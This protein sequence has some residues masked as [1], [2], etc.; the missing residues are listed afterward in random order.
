M[1]GLLVDERDNLLIIY[2]GDGQGIKTITKDH[3][4]ELKYKEYAGNRIFYDFDEHNNVKETFDS[5]IFNCIYMSKPLQIRDRNKIAKSVYDHK[6][7]GK[8]KLFTSS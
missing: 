2:S 5:R 6:K 8:M 1:G 7:T 3:Y 4:N